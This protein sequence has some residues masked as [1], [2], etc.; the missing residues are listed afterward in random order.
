MIKA[1]NNMKL[2]TQKNRNKSQSLLPCSFPF[3][4]PHKMTAFD[5]Q[6]QLHQPFHTQ[7]NALRYHVVV[8]KEHTNAIPHEPQ[9]DSRFGVPKK[10][11]LG[12]LDVTSHRCT[13]HCSDHVPYPYLT[14]QVAWPSVYEALHSH[15]VAAS[16]TQV[17]G[18][19]KTGREN[20][21]GGGRKTQVRTSKEE[22]KED[23]RAREKDFV[24][25]PGNQAT[26]PAKCFLSTS[27]H[28]GLS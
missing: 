3:R 19:R 26:P 24:P 8:R 6:D 15:L 13:V 22:R 23:E 4:R 18:Q 10:Q 5:T 7:R 1:D 12:I 20:G 27:S 11:L 21:R 14:A 16:I 9:C 2:Q 28:T 25:L 17:R